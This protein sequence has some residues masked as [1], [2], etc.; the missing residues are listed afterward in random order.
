MVSSSVCVS[1][2]F[3]AAGSAPVHNLGSS[4]ITA[5]SVLDLFVTDGT[6]FQGGAPTIAGNG[7]I[8]M[9]VFGS[10]TAHIPATTIGGTVHGTIAGLG[11]YGHWELIGDLVVADSLSIQSNG[12]DS[13]SFHS[14]GYDIAAANLSYGS[15]NAGGYLSCNFGSGTITV[16]RLN[17][18]S[19]NSGTTVVRD[20]A[21]WI[22]GGNVTMRSNT[23]YLTSGRNSHRLDSTMTVTSAGKRWADSLVIDAATK[24][25]TTADHVAARWFDLKAGTLNMSA[26]SLHADSLLKIASGATL[27]IDAGSKMSL[28]RGSLYMGTKTLP[29]TYPKGRMAVFDGG[30]F[31]GFVMRSAGGD[32]VLFQPNKTYAFSTKPALAGAAGAKNAWVS[33]TPTLRDTIDLP[34]NDT[35]LNFY[36]RDQVFIDTVSCRRSNNCVSGGGNY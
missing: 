25:V 31:T 20:S 18:A 5:N 2:G 10:G 35:L 3:F 12:T 29:I 26:D 9:W 15:P 21:R 28:G 24:T 1:C 23:T 4:T 22:H 6:V 19:Y 11:G 27:T 17:P 13:V 14:A 34:N 7:E 32:S 8:R 33:Q 36:I 30:T 16:T